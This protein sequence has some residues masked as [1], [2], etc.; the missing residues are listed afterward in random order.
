MIEH[1]DIARGPLDSDDSYSLAVVRSAG[2]VALG[3]KTRGFGIGRLV[4]PGGKDRYYISGSGIGLVPG[5]VDV[6]REVFE[7]TGLDIDPKLFTQAAMLALDTEDDTKTVAVYRAYCRQIPL[8]K[9]SEFSEL[10]WYDEQRL[11]Y[12][13]M[14]PDY[15]QWLPHVLAGYAVTTFLETDNDELVGGMIYRQQLE[16]LNRAEMIPIE[17]S[18]P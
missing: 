3:R 6:S 11:P 4:L 7:E 16:P 14:P 12:D 2:G 13:E 9:S 17:L 18:Q 8:K 15:I 5:T 1:L 10:D